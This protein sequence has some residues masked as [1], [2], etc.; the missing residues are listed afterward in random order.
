M[1]E[2]LKNQYGHNAQFFTEVPIVSSNI[3]EAYK[4][5]GIDSINGRIDLL[6]IDENG[7]VHIR[8]FKVSKT[9]VGP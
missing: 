4:K 9:S 8:D 1:I 7:N 6:I 2:D 5:A 3:H